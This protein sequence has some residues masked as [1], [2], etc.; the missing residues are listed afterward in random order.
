MAFR[1]VS[2]IREDFVQGWGFAPPPLLPCAGKL[3]LHLSPPSATQD[4][5]ASFLHRAAS[6]GL[7][8]HCWFGLQREEH[9]T[10]VLQNLV[11]V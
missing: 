5:G 2:A 1:A 11:V 7:L 4:R 8:F 9:W 10:R 3:H 6:A